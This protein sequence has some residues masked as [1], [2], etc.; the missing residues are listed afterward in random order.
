[1]TLT[2]LLTHYTSH[3]VYL[4]LSLS[5]SNRDMVVTAVVVTVGQEGAELQ[6]TGPGVT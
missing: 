5:Q 2:F 3:L 4:G 1:M 6:G